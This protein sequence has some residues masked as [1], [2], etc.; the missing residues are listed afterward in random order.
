M[1]IKDIYAFWE[2]F[3][4]SDVTELLVELAGDKLH[5]KRGGA[6]GKPFSD[7]EADRASL[8]A[9]KENTEPV[10]KEVPKEPG[11]AD[12]KELSAIKAPLVGTFYR[13]PQPGAD[14]YVTVGQQV[15][16]GDVIGVIEAMKLMNEVTADKEGIVE[17]IPAADGSLVEYGEP[18]LLLKQA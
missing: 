17:A 3:E 6:D 18:L 2:R 14:P 11:E 1:E 8:Y 7:D 4:A 15:K 13:A 5:L 12:A 10:E 16:K 9:V